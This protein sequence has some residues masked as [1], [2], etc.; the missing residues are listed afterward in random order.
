[1]VKL[2][3][4][5]AQAMLLPDSDRAA[6]AEHLLGSL[7]G[8]LHEDDLGLAEAIRRDAELDENPAIG[9]TIDQLKKSLGR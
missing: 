2:A 6:L 4:I 5:E 7:P 1:M 8:V 9:L 3:E